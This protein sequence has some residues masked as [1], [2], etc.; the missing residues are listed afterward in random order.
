MNALIDPS[1]CAHICGLKDDRALGGTIGHFLK[2]PK[3]S[4]ADYE[5]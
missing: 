4:L 3:A 5:S 1:V 2:A